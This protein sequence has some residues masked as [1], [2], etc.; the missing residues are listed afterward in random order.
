M[1]R[2][3]QFMGLNR[4]AINWLNKYC[5]PVKY[6]QESIKT[7]ADGRVIKT[8]TTGEK[9]IGE[10]SGKTVEDMVGETI[11][12][13]QVYEVKSERGGFVEEYVQCEP[14]SGGPMI[15]LALRFAD[16][17]KPIRVSLW[18]STEIER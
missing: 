7:F 12:H 4:R 14:W 1:S 9:V 5:G 17:K 13:L 3:T 8:I 15:Y 16:S 6:T 11:Y 2:N 18:S 10:N